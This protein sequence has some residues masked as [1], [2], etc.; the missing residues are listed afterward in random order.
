MLSIPGSL[1]I[2]LATGPVDFRKSHDGL[3]AVVEQA[4]KEDLLSGSLFVFTNKRADRVKLLYWDSDGYVLFYKRLEVGVFRFP[5]TEGGTQKLSI[6]ASDFQMILSGVDLS[7][8]K[9]LKRYQRPQRNDSAK[10]SSKNL[11]LT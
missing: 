7:S 8:V 11:A 4:L 2:Y 1:K 5:R 9:R 6:S 3:A 10:E